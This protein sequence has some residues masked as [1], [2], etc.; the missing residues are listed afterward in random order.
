MP[1][2]QICGGLNRDPGLALLIMFLPGFGDPG[3]EGGIFDAALL[4]ERRA[5][6]AALLK[7]SKDLILVIPTILGPADPVRFDDGGL[8]L[9]L[10]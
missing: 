6:H 1:G 2:R 4:R 9:L 7:G 3:R 5:T 10:H 8:G